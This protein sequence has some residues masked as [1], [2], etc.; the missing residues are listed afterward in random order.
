MVIGIL[1]FKLMQAGISQKK[2]AKYLDQTDI[3]ISKIINGE[4]Y[5]QDFEFFCTKSCSL[6]TVLFN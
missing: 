6:I 1:R 5:N 4:Q 3:Y 2:F